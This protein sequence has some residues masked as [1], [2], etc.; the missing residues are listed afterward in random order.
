MSYLTDEEIDSIRVTRMIIHLFGRAD[1]PFEPQPEIDVQQEAFFRA[2][3]LSEAG[4]AVHSFTEHSNIKP[5]VERMGS[6]QLGFEPGGQE[7]ARLFWRDDFK[8][9]AS[10]LKDSS[11]SDTSSARIPRPRSRAG[12][13][14]F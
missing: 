2:R 10:V 14:P 8:I 4:D 3:I 5:I 13:S 9:G 7:L 6:G 1:Q 12:P 11:S